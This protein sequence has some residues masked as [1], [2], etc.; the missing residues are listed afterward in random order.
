VSFRGREGI[1]EASFKVLKEAVP[2]ARSLRNCLLV[3]LNL[4]QPQ[5]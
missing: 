4:G 1:R 2:T 5:V 3:I